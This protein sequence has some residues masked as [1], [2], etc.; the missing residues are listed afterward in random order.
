MTA[1][2]RP[3][4]DDTSS[5]SFE[6]EWRER[7]DRFAAGE[8]SL[9]RISGWSEHGLR[10]RMEHVLAAFA[11]HLPMSDVPVLDLGCG[12]GVY[13]DAIR[14]AGHDVVGADYSRGMLRRAREVLQGQ[15]TSLAVA[16]VLRLPFRAGAFGGLSNVGVL[17]H[18]DDVDGAVGEMA[19]VVREGAVVCLVTLN[20]RSGH[21]FAAAIFDRLRAWRQGRWRPKK[22]AVR[23][24]AGMLAR[25][26]RSVGFDVAEIRGVY[27][28]PGP[29][30]RLEPWLDRWNR[31]RLFGGRPL[32]LPMANAFMLIARRR[33]SSHG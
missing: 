13:C 21:A 16:D 24:T 3:P 20:R 5:A 4:M 1:G 12:T 23:R 25:T 11:D 15:P 14:H 27:I 22:H 30:R 29:L 10:R 32:L 17:Q 6:A 18:I 8:G 33:G 9:A 28:L 2:T 7:F 19:R 31:V 26:A